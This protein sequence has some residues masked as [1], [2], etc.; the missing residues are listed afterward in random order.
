MGP[1]LLKIL[2]SIRNDGD[3]SL[4]KVKGLTIK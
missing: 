3:F 4:P 1:N 2:Y